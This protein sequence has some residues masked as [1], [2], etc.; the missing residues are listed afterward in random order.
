MNENLAAERTLDAINNSE[1]PHFSPAALR[2]GAVQYLNAIPLVWKL[3]EVADA[4]NTSIVL[5]KDVP[6]LLAQKL[7]CGDYDVALIPV[8]EAIRHPEL[9]QVSDVCIASEGAVESIRLVAFKPLDEI[10]KVLLDSASRSSC[11]MLQVWLQEQKRCVCEFESLHLNEIPNLEV[12]DADYEK[13]SFASESNCVALAQYCEAHAIDACLLIGDKALSVP[14][15][16]EA[17]PWVY[18]L[19]KMW[20]QWVGLP[21]VYAS[22]FARPGSDERRISAI[23]NEVRRTS[24]IEMDILIINEAMKRRM[25]IEDCRDYLVKKIRYRLGG[26]ER[27]GA[28]VFCKMTQKYGLTPLGAQLSFQANRD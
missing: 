9:V 25:A 3:G 26:R 1:N 13:V 12:A 17:L 21:F 20:T 18:D 7:V 14:L 2:V 23:M 15:H 28:E 4:L 19:G 6:S 8:V 5:Q 22:W 24:Q 11:A 10:R 16:S 27:R